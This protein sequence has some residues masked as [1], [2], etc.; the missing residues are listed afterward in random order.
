M[1]R[2][3]KA[4][5]SSSPAADLCTYIL[6]NIPEAV[7]VMDLDGRVRTMNRAALDL[8]GYTAAQVAGELVDRFVA[9]GEFFRGPGLARLMREGAAQGLEAALLT[10]AGERLPVI[11][12]ASAVRDPADGGQAVAIIGAAQEARLPG[13]VGGPT[14]AAREQVALLTETRRWME[15]LIYLHEPGMHI[16]FRAPARPLS[17][18]GVM[19]L[20]PVLKSVLAL[21]VDSALRL[22]GAETCCVSLLSP[23]G[24]Q[25]AHVTCAG[26][27]ADFLQGYTLPAESGIHG[28][29]INT[30]EPL[31]VEDLSTDERVSALSRRMGNC[32]AVVA[33]LRIG[34]RAIGALSVFRRA[35]QRQPFDE[36]A[37]RLVTLF[38]DHAA[39]LIRNAQLLDKSSRRVQQ[40][41]AVSNV[42]RRITAMLDPR[43]LFSNVVKHICCSFH[44]A[45]ATIFL[46]EGEYLVSQAAFNLST[47]EA[48]QPVGAQLR[49][50]EESVCGWVAQ[51]G[52]PLLVPD[53]EHEPRYH[54]QPGMSF[55]ARSALAV[56]LKL[57]GQV[58][59]V[60]EV[61]SEHLDDFDKD[62][63]MTM[64]ALG[65]HVATAIETAW[66]HEQVVQD[67]SKLAQ[68]S[69]RIVQ[70]QE[71]ERRRVA[72]ELHDEIAQML[73]GVKLTLE[74]LT[75][76]L[77]AELTM[78][79]QPLG[80]SVKLIEE[81]LA[82]VSELS[83]ELRPA[84]LDD[85]GLAAALEWYVERFGQRT[86]IP[87]AF[88]DGGLEAHL[89]GDV[90]VAVYRIVQ[91]A[92]TNVARHADAR[93]VRVCLRSESAALQVEIEDD[94]CGFDVDTVL[95]AERV[96]EQGHFGLVGMRERA[97]LFDGQM[98]I[99][100]SPGEGTRVVIKLPEVKFGESEGSSI[101]D[102]PRR[103][104]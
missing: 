42:G 12:N 22:V 13:A 23:H 32:S 74:A 58:I 69:R 2:Q 51:T 60:L 11:F 21:V 101:G 46:V 98:Q 49:I 38:A 35:D 37:L 3:I 68:L 59:G 19:S 53:V 103:Q 61:Q 44:H 14:G 88:D 36:R 27:H 24:K 4:Y 15:E 20:G 86:G 95:G 18:A 70:A 50:G 55:R 73:T 28:L 56:P 76:E 100:S 5:P 92:L 102:R 64:R 16:A 67:Q 9:E 89:Q 83:L 63:L 84:M 31:L 34:E 7:V 91:E 78:S 43:Q 90:E 99:V 39:L 94:G 85:M 72:R 40:L 6:D 54:R 47:G 1:Q 104:Y 77:P 57:K 87:V 29:A 71:D 65:A 26:V 30:G 66:L 52:Q 81:A 45:H 33:P 96:G 82:Q 75:T 17:S 41:R 97:A 93:H 25:R 79:G 48:P 10:R 8:L 80:E 62:D